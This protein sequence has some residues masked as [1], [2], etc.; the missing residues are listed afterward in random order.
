[1]NIHQIAE[2]LNKKAIAENFQIAAL[3]DLRKKYLSKKILPG[4]IFTAKTIF[5]KDDIYAFHHGGRDEMQ[6]NIGEEKAIG[7]TLIT[8]YALCFSLE[9]SQSLHDP[10]KDLEPFRIRFNQCMELH[11]EFF[12]D[13]EMWYFQNSKR[14][15][16]FSARKITNKWFRSGTFIAIGGLIEKPLSE[17]NDSDLTE[18]LTGFDNLLPIY[19][20]CVLQSPSVLSNERRIAKVCWNIN[21]WVSPSGE[22]GKSKDKKSHERER[23]Y[24]HEEWLFD[25]EKLIDDY[26]YALLQPVENGR[27]TFI[28]KSFDIGLF[29]HNSE[30]G[31]DW[32]IGSIKHLEVIS[33]EKAKEIYKQYK[34]NGWLDE[35]AQQLKSV[36]GDVYHFKNLEPRDLFNIR[37]KPEYAKYDKPYTKVKNFA[38]IIGTY[39]YQFVRDT[40]KQKEEKKK[41]IRRNFKFKSGKSDKSLADRVST[42]QKKI[43][44]SKPLHDKI[45]T[46]LY[47][48]LVKEY[49]E[50]R[51][52]ME[53]DTGL[54]TRIDIAVNAKE[55]MLLY[56][57]KSYPSVMISIRAALGQLIEYAYYPNPIENLKELIIVSHI[58]I[59]E[60][61]KEY[62]EIIRKITMLKISY[63]SVDIDNEVVSEKY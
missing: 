48:H 33:E 41:I 45:Q 24:G 19:K 9:P 34:I 60:Q 52:G 44:Q 23:G 6:F 27:N 10:V 37:F 63:Q 61:D 38:A 22:E 49:G 25:F 36:K 31:E 26:H 46:I 1:M 18:I 62:L 54:A 53:N 58:P 13:F 2:A 56:E 42:R 47:K 28:N 15:G 4:S 35:M 17:L 43:V 14:H 5:D 32:W 3:P 40:L 7:D 20:F 51:V 59:E 39:H 30:T 55:G 21:N 12:H 50:P 57:V 29:S 16:N 11:P 8:R